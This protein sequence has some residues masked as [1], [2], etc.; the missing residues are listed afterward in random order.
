MRNRQA[1]T[2]VTDMRNRHRLQHVAECVTV[3]GNRDRR[4]TPLPTAIYASLTYIRKVW[5]TCR[6]VL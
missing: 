3:S 5:H 6:A 4:T 2:P 1:V